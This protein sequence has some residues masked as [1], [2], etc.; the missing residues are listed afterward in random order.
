MDGA[1]QD[2]TKIPTRLDSWILGGRRT[3]GPAMRSGI[4]VSLVWC[5]S[6]ATACFP[7]PRD[8]GAKEKKSLRRGDMR[9]EG[10][11]KVANLSSNPATLLPAVRVNRPLHLATLATLYRVFARP[12]PA[13]RESGTRWPTISKVV[14]RSHGPV[15][16]CAASSQVWSVDGVRRTLIHPAYAVRGRRCK[17][18]MSAN[19]SV[20]CGSPGCQPSLA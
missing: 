17:G 18:R 6:V 12:W 8:Q 9:Q 5:V 14:R 11:N 10:A 7:R 3:S 2:A 20:T 13:S 15:D 19:G 1:R 16:T 4:L